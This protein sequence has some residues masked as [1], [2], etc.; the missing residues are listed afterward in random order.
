MFI[1]AIRVIVT[2]SKKNHDFN[3]QKNPKK[4]AIKTM[5]SIAGVM[6]LFGLTWL[7]GALTIRS[8]SKVFQYLFVIFNAFQGFFFFVFICILGKDGREFW[9]QLSKRRRSTTTKSSFVVNFHNKMATGTNNSKSLPKT[10]S[11]GLASESLKRDSG[12]LSPIANCPSGIT[13]SVSEASSPSSNELERIRESSL[14]KGCKTIIQLQNDLIH[15]NDGVFTTAS[16]GGMELFGEMTITNESSTIFNESV[17]EPDEERS[18]TNDDMTSTQDDSNSGDMEINGS[19]S[20]N[21]K[22][23][24]A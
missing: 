4:L 13:D 8:A 3:K 9:V 15:S 5:V 24:L 6:I 1:L 14:D 10:G 7:F 17:L 2:S 22:D 21:L 11:T 20:L 16:G 18:S 19:A 12:T 23:D